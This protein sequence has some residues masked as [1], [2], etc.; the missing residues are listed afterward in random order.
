VEATQRVGYI[1]F[2]VSGGNEKRSQ[3]GSATKDARRNENAVIVTT[4]QVPAFVALRC[5]VEEA[6]AGG[7]PAQL[8]AA[9]HRRRAVR[10][11]SVVSVL[12]GHAAGR[13]NT[14]HQAARGQ[15]DASLTMKLYA[16][17]RDDALKAAGATLNRVVISRDTDAG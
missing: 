7:P 16:N 17:S 11:G 6:M 1:E 13:R 9:L 12:A 2:A 14:A 15:K 10:T 4:Q 5:A 3:M 8:M